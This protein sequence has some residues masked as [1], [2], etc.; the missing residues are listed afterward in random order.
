MDD[1]DVINLVNS[2]F[3][4]DISV[5]LAASVY[6]VHISSMSLWAVAVHNFCQETSVLCLK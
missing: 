1:F 4:Q 3:F 2:I 6:V 5:C